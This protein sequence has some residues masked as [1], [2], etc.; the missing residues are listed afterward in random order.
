MF[1]NKES[2][3]YFICPVCYSELYFNIDIQ[4][5]EELSFSNS[6]D[7]KIF[8]IWSPCN[9]FRCIGHF[10]NENEAVEFLKIIHSKEWTGDNKK[11]RMREIVDRYIP[12]GEN[13]LQIYIRKNKFI[14]ENPD[15]P[16]VKKAISWNDRIIAKN[17]KEGE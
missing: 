4:K 16:W 8:H 5:L 10:D 11:T 3:E 9:C 13:S 14:Q 17:K 1:E 12:D 7:S 2:K 6:S 15:S